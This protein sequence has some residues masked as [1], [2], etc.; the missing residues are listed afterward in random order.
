MRSP[1]QINFN[2]IL[3]LL[4]E[5]FTAATVIV[6]ARS[7]EASCRQKVSHLCADVPRGW[8][9]AAPC[10]APPPQDDSPRSAG[11]LG[12]TD[13]VQPHLV[14]REAVTQR[15]SLLKAPPWA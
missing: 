12:S 4:L 3:L 5:L 10:R 13:K 15:R 1:L 9:H 7:G 14:R 6:S 2:L 8:G 11:S